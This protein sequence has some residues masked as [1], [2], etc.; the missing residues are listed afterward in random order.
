MAMCMACRTIKSSDYKRPLP[1]AC[2]A[3]HRR[4]ETCRACAARKPGSRPRPRAPAC[5]TTPGPSPRCLLDGDAYA[6]HG[7]QFADRLAGDFFSFL[8]GAFE[9]FH[10]RIHHRILLLI[11]AM[12]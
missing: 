1:D 5:W 11:V 6:V 4:P 9:V 2:A 8:P 7:D 12:R 3:R 10:H